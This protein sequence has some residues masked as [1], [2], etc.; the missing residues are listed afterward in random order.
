M[1]R[2][3]IFV[4]LFV[5]VAG[6]SNAQEKP[7]APLPTIAGK[8]VGLE[9]M[10]GYFNLYWDS[11]TG[12]IWLE[13]DKWE[14]EVLYISSLKTGVGS[15]DIGLD[16]GQLGG[17]HVVKFV[18]SGPKVLLLEPNFAYRA[19]SDNPDERRSVEEAFA[20]SV[21]WGFDVAAEEG[22]RLLVDATTF[23]L[24]DAHD[25]VTRL[26][27]TGQGTY[28]LDP[29]RS[30]LY[31]PMT[32]NFPLNTEV[33]ATLTFTGDDPGRW[34][35]SVVP[36]PQAVTVREHHSFVQLPDSN[37]KPRVF[38]PRA[39]YFPTSYFDYA[40]PIDQPINKMF[41]TRHRLEKKD[42]SAPMSDPVKPIVY[43]VDRG[44]P[45]PIRSALT[46]GASWWNQAFTAAGYRNAFEVKLMPEGADPMDVRYNVIQWV[47]RSTRGWSYGESVVDPRTGEI[48]QGH[49]SLGSLRVRQDFLIA[50]GLL[51][52]YDRNKSYD[53]SMVKMAIARIRQLAA[54]EVGHTLGL[55]HNYIASTENRAS[56]MDYPAPLVTIDKNNQLD[57]SNAYGT[58]IGE[59]DKVAIAYGYQDFPA[60]TDES[61]ALKSI[62][63]S[64]ASRGLVFLTD[65]DAR[66][67]GSAHPQVHLWDNGVNA[68][69]ELNRMMKVREI[70]LDNFSE[71]KIRFDTPMSSLEEVFVPVY[72]A[73]R[74]QV[75]AA[76]KVLGGLSFTY[77]L[78]GDGQTVTEIVPPGEQR[79]GI[80]A[81]LSTISPKALDIPERILKLIPPRA[82]GY[83]RTRELFRSRTDPTFDPLT[84][85]ETAADMTVTLMLN[86]QRAARLVDY[87]ARDSRYPGL[88]EVVDRLVNA[89]WKA[90]YSG[91]DAEVNRSV[92][93]VVLRSLIGL[94]LN[95]NASTQ[96]RAI[97]SLKIQE[98]KDWLTAQLK[99]VKDEDQRAHFHFALSTISTFEQRPRDLMITKPVTPPDG[100]PIGSGGDN[101]EER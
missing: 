65:Q 26:K 43:Y 35:Q 36:T 90:H 9:K 6:K 47:H 74:Y 85:A 58:S 16:R 66:P 8:T 31:L 39:G 49:V 56:V 23:F 53:S 68:V 81:L 15:N 100:Q 30:A 4:L 69:D 7:A 78:R 45:E 34:L 77:A 50:E 55:A 28:K 60:G 1:K 97:A 40:T 37:Y 51:A 91:Y 98:L 95:E 89:T 17:Q 93:E 94:A 72:L 67:Q 27:Q 38:D 52:H 41:I 86:P 82:F 42:P 59:W 19:M 25:V 96:S 2:I 92:D 57:V 11:H 13:I 101:W 83:P 88:D 21:L 10:P 44:A 71:D 33:E 29:S 63:T 3:A 76:S 22:E 70:A 87:H 75:E 99:T 14:K 12:K 5:F 62:V 20:Q 18:R 84:A 54:H 79:R 46:E 32:K 73:H 64:A 61:N 24:R 48:I 80:E